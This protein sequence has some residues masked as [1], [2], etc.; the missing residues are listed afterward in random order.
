[1]FPKGPL[2][3]VQKMRI[4]LNVFWTLLSASFVE[5]QGGR[6][7]T[8]LLGQVSLVMIVKLKKIA[9]KGAHVNRPFSETTWTNYCGQDIMCWKEVGQGVGEGITLCQKKLSLT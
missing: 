6:K 7:F 5:T 9:T 8:S 4:M 2:F 1:M 3:A